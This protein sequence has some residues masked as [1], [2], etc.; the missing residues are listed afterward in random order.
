M[1]KLWR[2]KMV[3]SK[4]PSLTFSAAKSCL[5]AKMSLVPS[6]VPYS[7]FNLIGPC[8]TSEQTKPQR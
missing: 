1:T 7:A 4:C 6:T 2:T 5:D 8:N 3:V